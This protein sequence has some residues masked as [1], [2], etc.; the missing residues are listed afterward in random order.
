MASGKQIAKENVAK[1]DAWIEER[2]ITN[3][4]AKYI[5]GTQL[6][7]SEIAQ[8][9]MFAT[10]ALRQNPAVKAML[11]DLEKELI[12][13]KILKPDIRTATEKATASRSSQNHSLQNNRISH[14]EQKSALL[15]AE[16]EALKQSLKRYEMFEQHLTDTGRMIKP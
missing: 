10:S 15:R 5:R 11:E 2:R 14:L 3:D 1:F 9:C 8:E 16:N 7:R 6:N 13:K 4:W 12:K